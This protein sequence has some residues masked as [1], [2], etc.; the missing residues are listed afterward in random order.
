MS[1]SPEPD[2][3]DIDQ[4]VERVASGAARGELDGVRGK[5]RFLAAA[6]FFIGIAIDRFGPVLFER[7]IQYSDVGL[8]LIIA[9]ILV[10]LGEQGVGRLFER[11]WPR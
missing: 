4:T 1:D 5:L 6:G 11:M 8:F 2:V 9:A 3:T 10:L 7:W